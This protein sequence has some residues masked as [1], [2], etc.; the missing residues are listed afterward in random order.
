MIVMQALGRQFSRF[1]IE[2]NI[3]IEEVPKTHISNWKIGSK[4]SVR[5]RLGSR[6]FGFDF[7]T[8]GKEIFIA[9]AIQIG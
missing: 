4:T 7:P 3:S 8:I 1:V 2:V 6:K 5:C 9:M